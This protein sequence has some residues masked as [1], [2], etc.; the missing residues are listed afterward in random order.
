[1]RTKCS[2]EAKSHHSNNPPAI[3]IST[4]IQPSYL[5]T[6]NTWLSVLKKVFGVS[7]INLKENLREDGLSSDSFMQHLYALGVSYLESNENLRDDGLSS[8]CF[9]S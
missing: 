2:S 1:V 6:F 9:T 3:T 8:D 4:H 5:Q 7:W